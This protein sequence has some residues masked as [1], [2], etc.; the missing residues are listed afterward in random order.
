MCKSQ[1]T[2]QKLI[3]LAGEVW[4]YSIAIC[5]L[6]LTVLTPV[7]AVGVKDIIKAFLPILYSQYWFITDYILLMIISPFLNIL[8]QH[9]SKEIYQKLLLIYFIIWSV[10]P[11][12]IKA[13]TSCSDFILFIF[14]YLGAGYIRKFKD[15]KKNNPK[16]NFI[17]ASFFSLLIICSN[18]L[19]IYIGSKYKISFFI[20]KNIHFAK[21]NSPFLLITAFELFLGFLKCRSYHNN[22]INR[23][24]STT[25]GIYLIH[26]NA[27]MRPYLWQSIFKN[28]TFYNSPFL[29]L[30]AFITI[31]LI[32]IICIFVDFLRQETIEKIYLK[33]SY[34]YQNKI[35]QL[36]KNFTIKLSLIL[37]KI[38]C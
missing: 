9:L 29:I 6:F 2:L 3:R 20:N 18:V 25:L 38:F 17:L 16:I 19:F 23:I 33:V 30:H 27:F 14:L 21:L 7:E 12:F 24:A 28:S 13:E 32:F 34:K 15:E 26:D 36:I 1:F 8:I 11:S 4:F 31:I 35:C 37:E 22:F 5:L 10:L